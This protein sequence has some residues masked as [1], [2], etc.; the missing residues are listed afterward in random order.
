MK[1]YTVE[2]LNQLSKE[3][4]VALFILTVPDVA[5]ILRIGR[6]AAYELVSSG[7]IRSIRI[8]N[9]IRITREDLQEYLQSLS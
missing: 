1:Q 4:I 3:Q 5:K 7:A 6:N 8:G 2:E 9:R